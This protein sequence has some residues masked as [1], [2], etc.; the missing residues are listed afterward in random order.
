MI[1]DVTLIGNTHLMPGVT[2]RQVSEYRS[3]LTRSLLGIQQR[4]LDERHLPDEALFHELLFP[5]G[6]PDVYLSHSLCDSDQALSVAIALERFGLKVF[7]DSCIWASLYTLLPQTAMVASPAAMADVLQRHRA[8]PSTTGVHMVLSA[9]VQ[10]M[11]DQCELLL[12]TDSTEQM[13]EDPAQPQDTL[14]M[15]WG[16]AA[17]HFGRYVARR[18]RVRNWVVAGESHADICHTHVPIVRFNNPGN[19][20]LLAWEKVR[21]VVAEADLLPQGV[22]RRAQTVL[23]G[24]YRELSLSPFERQ[25]LGWTGREAECVSR[26]R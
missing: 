1:L 20:H 21:M 7:V 8:W 19:R 15:P 12:F 14:S 9:V 18:A 17:R 5:A 24:L 11:V 3:A 16:F 25:L 10:R 6:Q 22:P 13:G 26:A 23:D 2:L 4:L